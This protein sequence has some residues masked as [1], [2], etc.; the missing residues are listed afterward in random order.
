MN[1]LESQ[2]HLIHVLKD[3]KPQARHA[4]LASAADEFIKPIVECAINKLN[5]NYKLNK[6]EESKLKKYKNRLRALVN[7]KIGFK[8]KRNFYFKGRVYSSA[9]RKCVVG[10]N[11]NT[12]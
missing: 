9:T 4:F 2:L 5:G 3:A 7:T 12:N 8:S 11:R 1:R 6:D 10:C